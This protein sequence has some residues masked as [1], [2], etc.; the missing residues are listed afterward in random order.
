MEQNATLIAH[1]DTNMV[2]REQLMAIPA[3]IGTDTFKPIAHFELIQ[4]MQAILEH[5]GISIVKEQFAIRSDGSKL[6]GTFDLSLEGITGTGGALGFRTGNDRSMRLQMITGMRVFV[7]DNMAFSGDEI[8][9]NRKHT[10]RLDL[11][12]ELMQAMDRF[13]LRYA[14]LKDEAV[15]LQ[16][17]SLD[18]NQAK[19]LIHDAFIREIMPLR[20]LPAVSRAYF[21]PEI[22]DWEPRTGWSLHNCFTGVMKEMTLNKR[23]EATQELG[24]IF[25]LLG[26]G[27]GEPE[28]EQTELEV[29]GE[30]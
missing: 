14:K 2:T 11:L 28:P 13:L 1:V 15:G 30:A 17:I 10:S 24:A 9:L 29:N 21:N 19:A 20:F 27:S 8:I 3:P 5:K 12:P 16:G 23:M 7:C 22:P 6:F 4:S 18:D 25:G 26:N